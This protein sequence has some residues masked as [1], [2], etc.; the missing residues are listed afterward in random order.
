MLVVFL[1]HIVYVCSLLKCFLRPV[2]YS[3]L[4]CISLG[5]QTFLSS[6]AHLYISFGFMFLVSIFCRRLLEVSVFDFTFSNFFFYIISDYFFCMYLL[7]FLFYIFF[8]TA[9]LTI[10]KSYFTLKF[11]LQLL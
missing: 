6:N 1:Y 10:P 11:R 9:R 2:C 3:C 5:L 8:F 4:S 7:C